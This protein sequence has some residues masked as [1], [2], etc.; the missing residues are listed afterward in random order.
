MVPDVR[1]RGE[2]FAGEAPSILPVTRVSHRQ[3]NAG[4][5]RDHLAP[6]PILQRDALID[7]LFDESGSMWSGNDAIMHRREAFLI[8]LEHLAAGG[9]RTTR[10]SARITTFDCSGP[11]EMPATKLDRTGLHAAESKLLACGPGGS[12]NLGPSLTAVE[13]E[14]FRGERVLVVFSDFELF[15]PDP[16]RVLADLRASTAA[17]VLAVVF[18]SPVPAELVGGRVQA[19]HIDPRSTTPTEIAVAVVEAA[20]HLG[21]TLTERDK[22]KA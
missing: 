14:G 8:A 4:A 22:G 1:V 12:S 21:L 7:A 9:R 5:I 11:M 6:P 10:W 16:A 19:M 15:D 17:V 3:L 20:R 18:R 13:S 2:S